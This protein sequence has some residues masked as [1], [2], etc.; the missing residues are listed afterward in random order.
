[1]FKH[2]EYKIWSQFYSGWIQPL[3][4]IPMQTPANITQT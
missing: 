4:R 2:I 3:K 1:M